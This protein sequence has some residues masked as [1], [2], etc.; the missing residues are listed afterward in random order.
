[1]YQLYLEVQTYAS[2]TPCE[3]QLFLLE[4]LIVV[5]IEAPR[6]ERHSVAEAE[7]AAVT[8]HADIN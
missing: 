3:A 2:M 6:E 4:E 8:S 5:L 7:A 1:M